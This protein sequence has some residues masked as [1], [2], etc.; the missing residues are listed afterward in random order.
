MT[1]SR[2]SSH[3]EPHFKESNY[4]RD[5]RTKKFIEKNG[6]QE[7]A[8]ELDALTVYA[9]ELTSMIYNQSFP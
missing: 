4:I 8:V 1:L 6:G 9:P 2:H 5:S 7:F 3:V